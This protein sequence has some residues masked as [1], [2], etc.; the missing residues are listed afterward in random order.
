MIIIKIRVYIANSKKLGGINMV[1]REM[2]MCDYLG[3]LRNTIKN[4]SKIVKR[5]IKN[6]LENMNLITFSSSQSLFDSETSI[7]CSSDSLDDIIEIT[8]SKEDLLYFFEYWEYI[9]LYKYSEVFYY[10][11]LPTDCLKTKVDELVAESKLQIFELDKKTNL[12]KSLGTNI[13]DCIPS[14]FS[15]NDF[16]YIK[17]CMQK[18]CLDANSNVI[19]YRY[20]VNVAINL[21]DG[22]FDIRYDG[23]RTGTNDSF[24]KIKSE[25]ISAVI[26]WIKAN[27][28]ISIY[29]IDSCNVIDSIKNDTSGKVNIFKQ[30]MS[31]ATGGAA[32]LVAYESK[33]DYILPFIGEIRELIEENDALFDKAPEIKKL[34]E[35]YLEEK[36]TTS[37]YPYIYIKS[38]KPVESDSYIVKIVLDDSSKKSISL[39][40]ITTGCKDVTMGRI[41]DAIEYLYN[42]KAFTKGEEI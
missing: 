25:I 33:D 16:F 27:L 10:D 32:E 11:N 28:C 19:D 34:L 37:I 7:F 23:L 39:Q 29:S 13:N 6:T 26:N 1:L 24:Q 22:Y 2:E 5:E 17:F 41:N 40:H 15:Q 42:V 9:K 30:M 31:M 38:K 12:I 36:E 18:S 4:N 20:T 35:N 14:C 21:K 3:I 8:T